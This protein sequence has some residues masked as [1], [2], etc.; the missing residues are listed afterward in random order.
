MRSNDI[1]DAIRDAPSWIM[2]IL[3]LLMASRAIERRRQNLLTKIPVVFHQPTKQNDEICSLMSSVLLRSLRPRLY[4]GTRSILNSIMAYAKRDP[5]CEFRMREEVTVTNDGARIALDWE[6]AASDKN[7]TSLKECVCQGPIHLPVVLVL[8]GV[9]TN[10]FFGYMKWMMKSCTDNGWI[11]VGMHARGYENLDR[12][13]TPRVFDDTHTNDLRFV[14]NRISNRLAAGTPLFLVGFSMGANIMVKYLGEEGLTGNL[15]ENVTGAASLGNPFTMNCEE[16]NNIWSKMLTAC[17]KKAL[18]Q[19]QKKPT[20]IMSSKY[21]CI[22]PHKSSTSHQI[23]SNTAPQQKQNKSVYSFENVIGHKPSEGL[24]DEASNRRNVA[25]VSIP[26]LIMSAD[27]DNISHKNT[28]K[29]LNLSNPNL[30][31]VKTESGGH[32]G[33][34]CANN[35]SP[36]GFSWADGAVTTFIGAL[37]SRKTNEA[38]ARDLNELSIQMI[39]RL[40][41]RL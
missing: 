5:D 3:I 41:S 28:M 12:T 16:L 29:I 22:T 21:Q 13:T 2:R 26:L 27:D 40:H 38:T 17:A 11:A 30:I 9:Q 10:E 14:V 20:E 1:S 8:H 19:H 25:N 35:N 39:R 7:E 6:I 15:P 18:L 34:H 4:L 24:W 37:I 36:D 32:L 31:I 23:A 33:W